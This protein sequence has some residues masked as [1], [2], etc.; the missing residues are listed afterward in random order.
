MINQLPLVELSVVFVVA[1]FSKI[2]THKV[3]C[4]GMKDI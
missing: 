2:F 4:G 3:K 1:L